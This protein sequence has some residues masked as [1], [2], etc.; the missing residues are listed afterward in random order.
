MV[1]SSPALSK[2]SGPSTHSSPFSLGRVKVKGASSSSSPL[3][4][5]SNSNSSRRSSENRHPAAGNP[6]LEESDPEN[7]EY[8]YAYH[9]PMDNLRMAGSTGM[10]QHGIIYPRHNGYGSYASGVFSMDPH[11]NLTSHLLPMSNVPATTSAEPSSIGAKKN[12]SNNFST[13]QPYDNTGPSQHRT[14]G[15]WKYSG[16]AADDDDHLSDDVAANDVGGNYDESPFYAEAHSNYYSGPGKKPM[17]TPQY[18]QQAY[19]YRG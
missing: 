5:N 4:S 18:L 10:D 12:A 15:S 16:N 19:E 3:A 2:R 14:D 8:A 11:R 13:H 1:A 7:H 17:A 9:T 6:Q